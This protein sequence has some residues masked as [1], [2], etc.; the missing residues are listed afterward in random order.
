MCCHAANCSSVALWADGR[1]ARV[2]GKIT[3]KRRAEIENIQL[4]GHDL[5]V[6][7]GAAA[8]ARGVIVP[9]AGHHL[10]IFV[11]AR[12]LQ[13]VEDFQLAHARRDDL[14]RAAV[15]GAG[16]GDGFAQPRQFVGILAAA[17]CVERRLDVDQLGVES[18][19]QFGPEG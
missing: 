9:G 11:N 6:A 3:A 15:H 19:R 5:A 10:A 18:L 13:L 17:Q 8:L 12:R 4:A 2:V 16:A 7:R 14:S 1:D